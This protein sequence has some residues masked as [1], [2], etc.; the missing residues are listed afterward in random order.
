MEVSGGELYALSASS[1]EMIP[2]LARHF[3]IGLY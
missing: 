2:G 1:R 3:K